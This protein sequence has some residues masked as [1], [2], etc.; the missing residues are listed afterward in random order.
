MEVR[1]SEALSLEKAVQGGMVGSNVP[2][3][4]KPS[5]TVVPS[6]ASQ[7]TDGAQDADEAQNP[8]GFGRE[9]V[10]ELVKRSSELLSAFDRQLKYELK[11]D[12]GIVQVQVIDPSDG[13]V[14]R[15][16]PADEVIKFIER[17][18]DESDDRVDVWA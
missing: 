3:A 6:R 2:R 18:R 11:E 12:A 10:K 16:I 7:Q 17:M 4:G 14:V 5:I 8:W 13:R 9:T 15:K 1:L